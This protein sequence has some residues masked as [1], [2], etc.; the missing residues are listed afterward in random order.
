MTLNG[1]SAL[2]RRKDAYLEP[3]AQIW[4]KIDPYYQRQKFRPM[5]LVSENIGC[6]RGFPCAR[7]SNH[8]GVVDDGYFWR[9][10][11][12][13]VSENFRDTANNIIMTICYP[14]S[15]GKCLQNE[16]TWMT[17]SGYFMTKCV[18]GQ[19]FLNQSV[20]MSQIVVQPLRFCGVQCI[21]RSVIVSLGRQHAQLT[22]C[23][24]AV[25]EL[26]V[27]NNYRVGWVGQ[28]NFAG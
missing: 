21:A 26:L 11:W 28:S 1:Q 17:L 10:R 16:W 24:S 15:T 8:I 9:F 14:L 12:L 25:A 2:C 27:T 13:Y 4:M 18:F 19:H 22:R 7:A 20:W 23:F 6:M 3:T 5:N